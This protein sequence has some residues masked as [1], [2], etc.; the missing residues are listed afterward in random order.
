MAADGQGVVPLSCDQA[1][2]LPAQEQTR[3]ICRTFRRPSL[4]VDGIWLAGFALLS[5]GGM[6]CL[7]FLQTS[8][9]I[10]NGHV[11][12]VRPQDPFKDSFN[13]CFLFQLLCELRDLL[14][15]LISGPNNKR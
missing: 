5:Q 12:P 10:S 1:G 8:L 9:C 11:Y 15:S 7:H 13:G 3:C 14:A 4:W 6:R 2:V